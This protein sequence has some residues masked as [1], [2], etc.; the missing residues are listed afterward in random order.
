MNEAF[1]FRALGYPVSVGWGGVLL[2]A[3]FGF[4]EAGRQVNA[5]GLMVAVLGAGVVGV[6]ILVHEL[7]HAVSADRFGMRTRGIQIHGMGGVCAY[8]GRPSA[9][10]RLWISL[11]G[12]GAGLALG[13]LAIGTRYGLEVAQLPVPPLI[14]RALGML[15]WVNIVW[16]VLNLLPMQPLDGSTALLSGLKLR[17][18]ARRAA[19]IGRWVSLVTAGVVGVGALALH[20]NILFI[21]A[22]LSMYQTWTGQRII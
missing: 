14:G 5:F 3:L 8:A 19:E 12:P 6:S 21:I 11:A 4:L 7:G 13:L 1:S 9:G 20:M 16:S 18:S 17:L 15:V 10:Q 2:M 22:A